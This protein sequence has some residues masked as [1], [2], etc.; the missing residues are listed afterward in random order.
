LHWAFN[1]FGWID[2][3]VPWSED[4]IVGMLDLRNDSA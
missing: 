4:I 1:I 2:M 3:Y